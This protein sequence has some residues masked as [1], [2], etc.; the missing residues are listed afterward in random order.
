[1]PRSCAAGLAVALF[2]LSHDLA[3]AAPGPEEASISVPVAAGEGHPIGAN[4]GA[5]G[6]AAALLDP[7]PLPPMRPDLPEM[8]ERLMAHD[9]AALTDALDDSGL[10]FRHRIDDPAPVPRKFL[11]TF[12]SDIDTI[13]DVDLRKA[14]FLDALLPIVLKINEDIRADRRRLLAIRDSVEAGGIVPLVDRIWM[15][16]LA[17][18]YRL[19][20]SDLD[21]LVMRVDEVPPSM[22]LAQAAV[23]SGWGTSALARR[24]NALFGQITSNPDG[25]RA[26]HGRYRY[27][28]F[29]S[30][31]D[32]AEAYIRN[33]NS[34]PAY[35]AFREMR[36][37]Q[38]AA[39]D[40]LDGAHLMGGLMSYSVKGQAYIRYVR[41]VIDQ[42]TLYR[43]DG[44]DLEPAADTLV[45]GGDTR[46]LSGRVGPSAPDAVGPDRGVIPQTAMGQGPAPALVSPPTAAPRTARPAVQY[47]ASAGTEARPVA[48][49]AAA[50]GMVRVAPPPSLAAVLPPDLPAVRAESRTDGPVVAMLPPRLSQGSAYTGGDETDVFPIGASRDAAV[51]RLPVPPL[52]P[53]LRDRE[54][55]TTGQAV[56]TLPPRPPRHRSVQ[57]P[58]QPDGALRQVAVQ[59]FV[60]IPARP[61]V[62]R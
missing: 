42:N 44:L 23:E 32:S 57:D 15:R 30:L 54:H 13:D 35:D 47:Q 7:I 58:A 22:A 18:T 49:G 46:S 33:L 3:T 41:R 48:H 37:A 24:A 56:A 53:R 34:H 62:P 55:L 39:G 28:T 31:E 59:P 20:R 19:E 6:G 51:A 29:T 12:P 10:L 52:P 40:A 50:P 17:E 1:M 27:A 8:R 61:P 14:V 45:A 36:A 4:G 2:A 16:R 38:R 9:V 60:A 11:L 21:A 43:L 25:I 26:R 5:D